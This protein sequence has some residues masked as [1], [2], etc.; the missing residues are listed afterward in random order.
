MVDESRLMQLEAAQTAAQAAML[1]EM[2]VIRRQKASAEKHANGLERQVG[3]PFFSFERK[4]DHGFW[5]PC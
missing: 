5:M 1:A 4:E 2:E 3:C